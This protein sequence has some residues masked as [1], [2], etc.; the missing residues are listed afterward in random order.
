MQLPLTKPKTFET[1]SKLSGRRFS[2]SAGGGCDSSV[3]LACPHPHE[4]GLSGGHRCGHRIHVHFHPRMEHLGDADS[5]GA[6][7]LVCCAHT[8]WTLEGDLVADTRQL[9]ALI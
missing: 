1:T 6:V 7:R 2:F 9:S 5:H 8:P 4:A 3:L